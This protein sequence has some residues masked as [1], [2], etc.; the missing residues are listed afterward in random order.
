MYRT[1]LIIVLLFAIYSC[2][3]EEGIGGQAGIKGVINMQ[4]LNCLLEKS[5]SPYPAMDVD[6]YIQYG[7]NNYINDK[8][9]TSPT[10]DFQFNYLTPGDYKIIIYSDDTLN[11][12]TEKEIAIEKRVNINGKKTT[13]DLSVI[14]IYKH[15]D[16]NDGETQVRGVVKKLQYASGTNIVID[17]IFAQNT[18]VYLLL[19]GS[20]TCFEDEET[21]HDGSFVFNNVIPGNYSLYVLSE[22]PFSKEDIPL[23]VDFSINEGTKEHVLETIYI[24]DF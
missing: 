1:L 17:T 6:V 20:N 24:D 19:E 21:L 23:F 2:K 5:G 3:K 9:E 10:G 8:V 4:H 18:D 22:Q 14:S 12:K 11:F 15:V 13:V 16:I 7:N